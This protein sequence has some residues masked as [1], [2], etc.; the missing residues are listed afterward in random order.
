MLYDKKKLKEVAGSFPTGV[1]VVSI[2][3]PSGDTHGMT[4]SS[5]LSLSL[6]PP[7]ILFAVKKENEIIQFIEKGKKI[8]IS[9][10]SEDMLN[11]SDHFANINLMKETPVFCE[12]DE[13]RILKGS[14]AWYSVSVRKTYNEGD[15]KIII[16]E[17]IN[18]DIKSNK[19]P[20]LYYR[21]YSKICRE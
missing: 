19:N 17:I 2:E 4:A 12:V 11:E 3:K 8:G 5:F 14:I 9:I 21:G 6:D 13:V 15:H 7:M 1:T 10:L 18:L 20:L 16:C